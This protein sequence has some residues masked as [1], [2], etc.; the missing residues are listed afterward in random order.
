M[1]GD[2]G[3]WWLGA[4]HGDRRNLPAAADGRL[5]GKDRGAEVEAARQRRLEQARQG[6]GRAD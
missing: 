6:T 4:A 5:D 3:D 1:E 2:G